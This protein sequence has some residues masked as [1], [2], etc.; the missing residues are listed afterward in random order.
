[1]IQ[2]LRAARTIGS[3][4]IRPRARSDYKLVRREWANAA[5]TAADGQRDVNTTL[6]PL[7]KIAAGLIQQRQTASRR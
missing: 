5:K 3:S 7:R 1:L 6:P 4:P 2:G